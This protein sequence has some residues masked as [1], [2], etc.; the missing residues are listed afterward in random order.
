MVRKRSTVSS[1]SAS[2][3]SHS[4]DSGAHKKQKVGGFPTFTTSLLNK[5]GSLAMALQ[6]NRAKTR[7][8]FVQRNAGSNGGSNESGGGGVS[9]SYQKCIAFNHVVFHHASS[10]NSRSQLSKTSSQQQQFSKKGM[11]RVGTKGNTNISGSTTKTMEKNSSLFSKLATNNGF[12]RK[13]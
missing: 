1:N 3:L 12:Q 13:R 6:A 4:Q 7:T 10:S 5:G 8:S 2:V 9:S 11:N